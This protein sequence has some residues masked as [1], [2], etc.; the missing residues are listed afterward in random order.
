VDRAEKQAKT[1][2]KEDIARRDALAR[3]RDHLGAGNPA[4]T[5]AVAEEHRAA[6]AE[7]F[8]LTAKPV[9]YVANVDERGA[10]EP[11]SMNR[12]SGGPFPLLTIWHFPHDGRDIDG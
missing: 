11:M 9:M 4:R 7:I 1:G 3:L 2:K 8:L 12:G 10:Q 6:V 5:F